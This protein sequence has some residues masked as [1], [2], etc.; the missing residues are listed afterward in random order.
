MKITWTPRAMHSFL[1]IIDFINAKWTKKEVQNFVD[2][3]EKLI[4]QISENPEMFV[5]SGKRKN[6]RKG[7]VNELVSLFYK[8]YSRKKEIELLRFWD[9]RQDP[10]RLKI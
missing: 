1:G 2:Q 4:G 8:D 6:V 3:T 5:A 10:K 9:N 7:F